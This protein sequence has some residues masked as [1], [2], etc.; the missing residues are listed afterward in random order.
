MEDN[1]TNDTQAKCEDGTC[2]SCSS[3]VA[4][5]DTPSETE[6]PK[7]ETPEGASEGATE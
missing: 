1:V 3:C 7:T 4:K 5:T 2:G 6:P